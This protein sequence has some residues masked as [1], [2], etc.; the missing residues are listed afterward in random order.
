MSK[1]DI[2]QRLRHCFLSKYKM[3]RN[4]SLGTKSHCFAID[5][6]F[7]QLAQSNI[8]LREELNREVEINRVNEKKIR[9]LIRGLEKC[10]GELIRRSITITDQENKIDDLK[11]QISNLRKQLRSALKEIKSNETV[12]D[13]KNNQIA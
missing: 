10:E 13:S 12:I 3:E 9:Q 6:A 4:N 7:V 1:V 5:P 11:I 2:D 8:E